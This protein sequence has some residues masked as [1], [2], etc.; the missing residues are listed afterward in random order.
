MTTNRHFE[1]QSAL[2]LR[3]LL[4]VA[5]CLAVRGLFRLDTL[6]R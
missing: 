6:A 1:K 5:G 3:Y 4:S 2:E